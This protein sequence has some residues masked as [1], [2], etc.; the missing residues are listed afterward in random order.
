MCLAAVEWEIHISIAIVKGPFYLHYFYS[1]LG[2][3]MNLI[4][5][6]VEGSKKDGNLDLNSI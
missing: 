2:L 4:A 5:G 3:L 1:G 6:L